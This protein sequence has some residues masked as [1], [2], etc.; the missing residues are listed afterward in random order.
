MHIEILMHASPEKHKRFIEEVNHWK[1]EVSDDIREGYHTPFVS[2]WKV[3]DIRVPKEIASRFTRDLKLRF[4]GTK[5]DETKAK[6]KQGYGVIYFGV[7]IVRKIL[8]MKSIELAEGKPENTLKAWYNAFLI[9][10]KDDPEQK[11]H[12]RMKEVL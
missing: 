4:A 7:N 11:N 9:G 8:G 2:E 3:Y 6:R 12:F 5:Y 10:A 1:Y